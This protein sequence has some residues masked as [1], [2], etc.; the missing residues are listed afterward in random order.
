MVYRTS[1]CTSKGCANSV[2]RMALMHVISLYSIKQLPDTD[3][4]NVGVY[5]GN[6]WAVIIGLLVLFAA[7]LRTEGWAVASGLVVVNLF[8]FT[9]GFM[10]DMTIINELIKSNDGLTDFFNLWFTDTRGV[11][12][13]FSIWFFLNFAVISAGNRGRFGPVSYRREPGLA[14]EWV[15]RNGYTFVVCSALIFGLMIRMAW[16]IL[17]AMNGAGTGQW[18]MT[19]GSDPWYMKRAVDYVVMHQSHFILDADRYL[20]L[21]HI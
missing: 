18:D 16:N 9:L 17:P 3:M 19:G 8:I 15:S 12:M 10:Q 14:S 11:M 20:S 4:Y 1:R 13:W 7:Y 6:W 21:I 5:L 2:W